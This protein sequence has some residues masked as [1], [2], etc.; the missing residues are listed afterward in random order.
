[1]SFLNLYFFILQHVHCSGP[2]DHFSVK[3]QPTKQSAVPSGIQGDCSIDEGWQN[4]MPGP[5]RCGI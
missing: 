3:K 4:R 5:L 1:M 2:Q